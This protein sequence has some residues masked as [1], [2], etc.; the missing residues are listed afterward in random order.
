M[1]EELRSAL[2]LHSIQIAPPGAPEF[3]LASGAT[4]RYY[5]DVRATALRADCTR[6]LAAS[7][8]DVL[9][10]GYFGP[11]QAVAGV[12]LGGCHLASS[13][14]Y[15]SSL[16]RL[17]LLDAVFVRKQ[18]KD[19]GTGKL[20]ESPRLKPGTA[21]VLLEDVVTS[22]AS[23]LSAAQALSEAGF[24]VA[25]ILAV[26]DRR[27]GVRD[28]NLSGVPFLSLFQIEEL[29]PPGFPA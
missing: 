17:G 14:A 23:S 18:A 21:V 3:R 10:N 25:G 1:K 6:L 24:S 20:V 19:H 7:L 4:S 13:V 28:Q 9:T 8:Y 27:A 26:V 5:C 16:E 2:V 29:L 22:G 12:V 15:H 11:V